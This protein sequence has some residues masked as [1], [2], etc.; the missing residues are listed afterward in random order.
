M[1]SA[2][3]VDELT[4]NPHQQASH[5]GF[6]ASPLPSLPP[7]L[8]GVLTYNRQL[9]ALAPDPEMVPG[10][11]R[12]SVWGGKYDAASGEGKGRELRSLF[13]IFLEEK[14]RTKGQGARLCWALFP[15][16]FC[17]ANH[18]TGTG[19][20]LLLTGC[21]GGFAQRHNIA[22]KAI[23]GLCLPAAASVLMMPDLSGGASCSPHLLVATV[24]EELENNLADLQLALA[25]GPKEA[26][27]VREE[28]I[29][30]A[31]RYTPL[32]SPH[33]FSNWNRSG[34]GT[35]E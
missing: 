9:D 10:L 11:G 3:A 14:L 27:S 17:S 32:V 16:P 5:N 2:R 24:D 21:G 31:Y 35:R 13:R 28:V 6:G 4:P 22:V 23:F 26:T 7:Q 18:S 1:N 25:L 33:L 30:T 20:R 19:P 29:S 15:C 34:L 12:T 8:D